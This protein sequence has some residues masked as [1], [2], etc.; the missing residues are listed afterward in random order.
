[1]DKIALCDVDDTLIDSFSYNQAILRAALKC[2]G[3][4]GPHLYLNAVNDCKNKKTG[5]YDFR[6]AFDS[7][8]H[9]HNGNSHNGNGTDGRSIQYSLHFEHDFSTFV[10]PEAAEMLVQLRDLGYSLWAFS[11]SYP[12][13]LS[14]KLES[15]GLRYMFDGEIQSEPDKVAGFVRI[16]EGLACEENYRVILID[17]SS[18]I[19][20]G[21]CE[22]ARDLRL[23]PQQ[24]GVYCF[25][26]GM[27]GLIPPD[28]S[29]YIV[30]RV[31]TL[32][33]LTQAIRDREKRDFNTEVMPRVMRV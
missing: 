16:I 3:L 20:N 15:S 12:E 33:E 26:H 5:E 11:Q 23:H 17:D 29:P 10:I 8:A 9:Y 6:T 4:K 2:L 18:R 30:K 27:H 22:A 31:S 1:M 32:A 25:D 21:V 14:V 28:T 7:L 24:F 13:L 19:I